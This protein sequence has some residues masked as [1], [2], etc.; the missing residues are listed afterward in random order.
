MAFFFQP[1]AYI[2]VS[3]TTS[4]WMLSI[5][6]LLATP[7]ISLLILFLFVLLL[8]QSVVTTLEQSQH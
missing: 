8:Y 1:I 5:S 7:A 6:P 2:S 3:H 4:M